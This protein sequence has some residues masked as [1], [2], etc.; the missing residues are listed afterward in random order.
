ML[1]IGLCPFSVRHSMPQAPAHQVQRQREDIAPEILC[2]TFRNSPHLPNT[3]LLGTA[4]V[5]IS[6][7]VFSH[8]GMV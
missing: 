3:T 8:K 5:R 1:V 2:A 4:Q 7:W 6:S